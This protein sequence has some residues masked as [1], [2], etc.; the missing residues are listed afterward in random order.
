VERAAIEA[1]GYLIYLGVAC[2]ALSKAAMKHELLLGMAAAAAPF[3]SY[4][5]IYWFKFARL[6]K[7]LYLR[8]NKRAD[9]QRSKIVA[10]KTQLSS[11]IEVAFDEDNFWLQ[12]DKEDEAGKIVGPLERVAV[13]TIRSA[14]E[15]R[16]DNCQVQVQILTEDKDRQF[17]PA[18]FRF[19]M[20]E[21][22]SLRHGEVAPRRLFH[23][24][25]DESDSSLIIEHFQ[26]PKSFW[27]PAEPPVTL[28]PGSYILNVE[29]LSDSARMAR[30]RVKVWHE[31]HSWKM[32]AQP[33]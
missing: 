16:V 9:R 31:D 3:F 15:K 27:E 17:I 29:V 21:P 20:C 23:Y 4:P 7:R 26:K 32:E 22:F 2:L 18:N 25:F 6:P 11:E 24:R 33:V 10:L 13:L 30:T 28:L 5:A 1:F 14:A 19:L 8:A 12:W